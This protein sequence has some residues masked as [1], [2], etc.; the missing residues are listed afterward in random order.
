MCGDA[1]NDDY[2]LVRERQEQLG[3]SI[4]IY[5]KDEGVNEER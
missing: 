3:V 5:K 2:I 4:C 1:N